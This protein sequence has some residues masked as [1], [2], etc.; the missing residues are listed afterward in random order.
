MSQYDEIFY[1]EADSW[2]DIIHNNH[3]MT[4]DLKIEELL[5]LKL[6][7]EK[8][9]EIMEDYDELGVGQWDK[10]YDTGHLHFEQALAHVLRKLRKEL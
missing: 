1:T 5:R 9:E 6:F 3:I 10:K 8:F 7:R 4:A 2:W